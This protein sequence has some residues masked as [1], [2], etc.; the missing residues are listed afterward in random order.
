MKNLIGNMN[1]QDWAKE[2]INT[3]S[4]KPYIASDEGF[5]IGWFANAIMTGLDEGCR[6][7]KKNLENGSQK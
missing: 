7:T 2:F 4:R 3:I 1:A 5:M 6:I